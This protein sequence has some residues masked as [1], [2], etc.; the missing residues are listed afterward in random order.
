[1]CRC[2]QSTEQARTKRCSRGFAAEHRQE[3]LCPHLSKLGFTAR[4]AA[5]ERLRKVAR[6]GSEANTPGKRGLP[7]LC[8][9]SRTGNLSCDHSSAANAAQILGIPRNQGWSLRFPPLATF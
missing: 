7:D 5:A 9:V 6:G 3:C 8:R 1:M 2:R 4:A